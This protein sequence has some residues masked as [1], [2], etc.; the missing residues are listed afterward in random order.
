[1]AI[2]ISF[3]IRAQ[4]CLVCKV[5][6]KQSE[7]LS[8]VVNNAPAIVLHMDVGIMHSKCIIAAIVLSVI[9]LTLSLFCIVI[10]CHIVLS[11]SLY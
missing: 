5:W 10:V 4:V 1:M 9:V 7:C 3:V 11:L 2:V 8:S 6:E